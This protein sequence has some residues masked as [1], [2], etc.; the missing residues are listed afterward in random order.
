[1]IKFSKPDRKVI[2]VFLHCSDSDI[3][4]HDNIETITR[5]HVDE[6]GWTYIG[7]QYVITQDGV[8]HKGRSLE[9]QTAAQYPFNR[10]TIAICLTGRYE[11]SEAQ[12]D[13]LRELCSQIAEA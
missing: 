7:Y 4:E 12:Y 1:M 6:N 11:F 8:V 5:W 13:S 9:I 10:D 3:P 2:K